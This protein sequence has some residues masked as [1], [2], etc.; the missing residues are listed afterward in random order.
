MLITVWL[1]VVFVNARTG[2]LRTEEGQLPRRLG[3]GNGSSHLAALSSIQAIFLAILLDQCR[4]LLAIFWRKKRPG[5]IA[6]F[7]HGYQM[8]KFLLQEGHAD[9]FRAR[10]EKQ[11]IHIHKGSAGPRCRPDQIL[12]VSS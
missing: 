3:V 12:Q 2:K 1:A 5:S 8:R 10:L 4:N 7:V 11:W 9:L 6:F